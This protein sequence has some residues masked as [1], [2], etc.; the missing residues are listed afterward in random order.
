MHSVLII[1]GIAAFLYIAAAAALYVFQ[2][3]LIYYPDPVHHTPS[4]AGL[5]GVREVIL[6]T[7][8][9]ERLIAWH[10]EAGPG[11]PT[12]LYFHGNVGGLASRA[13]RVARFAQAGYGV[14]MLSYRGYSGST[15][16][17]SEA[18]IIGDAALAYRYLRD[19][20]LSSSGIVAYGESLGTGVAVQLAAAHPVAALIL[21]APYTSLPAIGKTL[22]PFMPVETFMTDRFDSK[23]HIASVNAPL[24]ILHG[25]NDHTIPIELG[26][27]L[28]NAAT[29]PKTFVPLD[30]AG[31]SN[32]YAYGALTHVNRFLQKHLTKSDG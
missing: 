4:K 9:G 13:D 23:R 27:A 25:S 26:E 10:A 6:T 30:G 1:V 5:S 16:K 31:H 17:P 29:E 11:Q 3:N 14:F 18:A 12:L 21:D 28:F 2:R 7:P 20:G 15:G 22:Y 8:D 19:L 32:I 24:L